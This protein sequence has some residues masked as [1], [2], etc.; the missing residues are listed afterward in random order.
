MEAV[1][2]TL[3]TPFGKGIQTNGMFFKTDFIGKLL[4]DVRTPEE[5]N[6]LC[7]S[8]GAHNFL[9]DYMM[10]KVQHTQGVWVEI[11]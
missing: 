3:N 11:S 8:I 9:E 5:Y 7:E 2:A 6:K 4:D 1:L 10:K